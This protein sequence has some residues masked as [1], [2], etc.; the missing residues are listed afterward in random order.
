M[1]LS[2]TG[3]FLQEQLKKVNEFS[4]NI[5]VPLYTVMPNHLHAIVYMEKTDGVCSSEPNSTR[6][7]NP[8]LRPDPSVG[9]EVSFLSRYVSSLDGSVTK[10]ARTNCYE[11]GWQSRYHDHLIRNGK[12]LNNIADYIINNV[13]RWDADCFNSDE[14]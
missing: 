1:I 2:P 9:R 3:E 13:S 11:F 12:D 8:V 10:F 4:K 7:P 14:I 6:N 5:E